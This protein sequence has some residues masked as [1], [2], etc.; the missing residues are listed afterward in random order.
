MTTIMTVGDNYGKRRCDEKC[1]NAKGDKCECCCNGVNHGV[2]LKK[3]TEQT[4]S[5]FFEMVRQ[6]EKISGHKIDY[7]QIAG[8]VIQVDF[9]EGAN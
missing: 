6:Y 1:Y 4:Q 9:F 5:M 8:D 7:A 2:G 3:A